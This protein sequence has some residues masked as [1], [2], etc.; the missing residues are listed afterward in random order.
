MNGY[1]VEQI[2]FTPG[3]PKHVWLSG[4]MHQLIF[5]PL[6]TVNNERPSPPGAE[7]AEHRLLFRDGPPATTS[8]RHPSPCHP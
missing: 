8:P 1:L 5:F 6:P 2:N 7:H 3:N 4:I